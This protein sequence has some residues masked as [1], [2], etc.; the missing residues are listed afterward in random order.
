MAWKEMAS[1]PKD[2]SAVL[3]WARLKSIPPG[4]GNE[5]CAVVGFWQASIKQWKV[6][7]EYLNKAEELIPSYW[8]PIPRPPT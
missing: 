1:A 7:P 4:P 5:S 6:A 8:M 2:G 3:L